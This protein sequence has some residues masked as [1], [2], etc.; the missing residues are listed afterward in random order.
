[1]AKWEKEL[2]DVRTHLV[3]HK[4][5]DR[6]FP[7]HGLRPFELAQTTYSQYL[8]R[9][10]VEKRQ[11]LN[12]ILSNCVMTDGVVVPTYLEPFDGIA[13]APRMMQENGS[14]DASHPD[15]RLVKWALL[16]SNQ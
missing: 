9:S 16:D 15:S 10:P 4:E 12:F 1:M 11:M 7:A 13:S 5:A 2:G 14:L 8:R 6:K 3:A